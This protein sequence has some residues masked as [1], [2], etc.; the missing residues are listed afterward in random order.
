MLVLQ[1]SNCVKLAFWVF[2][3]Y[4]FVPEQ[5]TSNQSLSIVLVLQPNKYRL[6][7]P[8]YVMDYT[9]LQKYW[10]A[11]PLP[12]DING[13]ATR[14]AGTSSTWAALN[15]DWRETCRMC[16]TRQ[17][18]TPRLAIELFSCLHCQFDWPWIGCWYTH[19][20]AGSIGPPLSVLMTHFCQQILMYS[21]N[22]GYE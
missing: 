19:P 1:F 7:L 5:W 14:Q 10:V 22:H 11:N 6:I 9:H 21:S 15:K 8:W 3:A 16:T 20:N 13:L 18:L 2:L 17:V 4:S 12:L